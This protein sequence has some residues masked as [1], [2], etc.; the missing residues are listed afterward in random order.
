[1]DRAEWLTARRKCIGGSDIAAI[2]GCSKYTSP[3][4]VW[5]QKMDAPGAEVEENEFMRM[6]TF[7]EPRIAELYE[8]RTGATL[9]KGEFITGDPTWIGGTPD[10]LDHGSDTVVE[11]KNVG[12]YMADEWGPDG[13]DEAPQGFVVQVMWYM[14]LLLRGGYQQAALAP[15]I[16]GNDFRI[17][18][19]AFDAEVYGWLLEQAAR[20]WTD[21]VVA[22][23]E[24]PLTGMDVDTDFLK[25]RYRHS[26][27]ATVTAS[28]EIEEACAHLR[29]ARA[30]AKEADV[31]Q[32][33]LENQIKQFMGDASVLESGLGRFTWRQN[34]D[35]R[36]T[37]WQDVAMKAG[38]GPELIEAHTTVAPGA[39]VFRTPFSKGE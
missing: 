11:I 12:Q 2:V 33:E 37:A 28:L 23:R 22:E 10:Y 16:G 17:Y 27:E 20:F 34:K 25:K 9:T 39:R 18:P 19:V 26:T 29:L 7:L 4:Q 6:G 30:S 3:H 32:T 31:R 35:S 1:M 36:K 21:Y 15:L 38:A 14:G 5:L 13:T 8:E 24:P